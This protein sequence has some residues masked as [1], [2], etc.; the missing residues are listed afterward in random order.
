VQRFE[1]KVVVMAGAA[2]GMGAA[3]ARR[4][5]REGAKI[6]LGDINSEGAE[7]LVAEI[8]DAGGEAVPAWFDLA[9]EASVAA[10]MQTAIDTYGRLDGLH[11]NGAD[12][13][14]VTVKGDTDAVQ[15][16]IDVFDGILRTD[17]R[18]YLFCVRYA[19]PHMLAGGGGSI[20]CTVSDGAQQAQPWRV[21]YCAAKAGV[22][23]LV[24]HVALVWGPR[25]IRCNGV[26]PGLILSETA[27]RQLNDEFRERALSRMPSTR[28]GEPGD[29]AGAVA[30]LL[31][32]DADW[33]NGQQL[34]VNGG[35]LMK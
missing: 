10:L 6:V 27:L 21:A 3:T 2:T 15:I 24:R 34:S 22:I 7:R 28:L 31:S 4:L 25:G 23:S 17:L 32:E 26:S 9:D 13:R 18:G 1:N 12:L 5:A 33:V 29:I 19:I 35:L 8:V 20:V 14:D 11:A 16:D 30:Y